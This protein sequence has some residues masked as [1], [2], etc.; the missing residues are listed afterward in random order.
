MIPAK[1]ENLLFAA[2]LSGMMSL[3]IT[4]ITTWRSLAPGSDFL[5]A[6]C[7]A[8][9]SAW[10]F[11]FPAVIAVSPAARKLVRLCLLPAEGQGR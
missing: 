5:G 10:L 1:Y 3:L 2:L 4:G 6:W 9:L 11:A 8:W 7:G